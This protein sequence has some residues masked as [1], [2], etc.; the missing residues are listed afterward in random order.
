MEHQIFKILLGLWTTETKPA[1]S[2]ST[3]GA[4]RNKSLIVNIADTLTPVE[5]TQPPRVQHVDLF[6][7]LIW[8]IVAFILA[9]IEPDLDFLIQ[10]ND[11]EIVCSLHLC[12]LAGISDKMPRRFCRASWK[13]RQEEA[14]TIFTRSTIHHYL[15]GKQDLSRQSKFF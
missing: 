1:Q 7:A 11:I 2:A 12:L 10:L 4:V 5:R 15:F 13:K 8:L 9:A 6:V 14:L 3:K